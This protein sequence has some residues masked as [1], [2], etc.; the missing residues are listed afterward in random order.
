MEQL[1]QTPDGGWIWVTVRH[2]ILI[3][4]E[5]RQAAQEAFAEAKRKEQADKEKAERER[6]TM[7]RLKAK[8]NAWVPPEMRHAFSAERIEAFLDGL[9]DH[10]YIEW[11]FLCASRPSRRWL[12]P[13]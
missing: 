8:C 1:G 10:T 12:A 7:A 11:K 5:L 9:N 3:G 6:R 2:Q 13:L 4:K